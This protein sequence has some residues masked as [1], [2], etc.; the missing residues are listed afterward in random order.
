MYWCAAAQAVLRGKF[1]ETIAYLSTQEKSQVH[2]L[3]LYLKELD[4]EKT[5]PRVR[6]R[7]KTSKI[8]AEIEEIGTT[9]TIEVPDTEGWF[10]KKIKLTLQLIAQKH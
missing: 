5:E 9:K 7:K 8:R 4:T 3:T 6:T 10:F 1:V 2:S